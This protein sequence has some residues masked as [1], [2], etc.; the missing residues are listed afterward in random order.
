[1]PARIARKDS[2]LLVR[3]VLLMNI[4]QKQPAMAMAN[5]FSIMAT[6]TAN[7]MQAGVLAGMNGVTF[8]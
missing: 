6:F 7:V 8:A 4:A 2:I 5:A 3:S 1:M